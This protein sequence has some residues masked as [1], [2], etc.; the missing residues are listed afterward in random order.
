MHTWLP[1]AHSEAPSPVSALLSGALLNCAFLGILR[2]H[3]LSLA[4]GF[5]DFS[6]ELFIL[7][8][9]LS[10]LTATLFIVG[11]TD[12]KRMLAYSS[13]EHMGILLLG[14]G[15]G[16]L[17]TQGSMLQLLCHSLTKAALFLLAGNIL[18]VYHVKN[19]AQ[20]SGMRRVLPWSGP[21]WLAG[22]LA[23]TGSPP[24]GIFTSEFMILRSM[25]QQDFGLVPVLYLLCLGAIF[26]GMALSCLRMFLGTVPDNLPA[27]NPTTEKERLLFVLPPLLLLLLCA[28]LSL[29]HPEWLKNI[30]SLAAKSL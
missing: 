21:L 16:G 28:T 10:M 26:V 4:A 20:I 2:L 1:D 9:L 24:F 17:A 13:V 8:G 7:F 18:R 6:R 14:V 19:I 15:I 11:Q 29:Y 5:G 25:L 27:K 23:V 30:L 12:F 3:Q 22:F